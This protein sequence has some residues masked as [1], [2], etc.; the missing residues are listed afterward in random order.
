[1][2]EHCYCIKFCQKLGDSQVETIQK[3]QTVLGDDA[4]GVTQIKECYSRFKD[5]SRSVD[6]EPRSSR[7]STSQNDQAIA[8]VNTVVIRDHRVTIR[9]IAE[10]VDT[11][12]FLAHSIL[13]EDLAI[14][15]AVAKFILKLL[16]GQQTFLGEK[17]DSCGLPGSL[18]S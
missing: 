9:E 10:E 11:S 17:L 6:N 7:L 8:K 15:R 18:L 13:T 3:I 12:T 4:M 1:M 14:K 16:T 5:G 2:T